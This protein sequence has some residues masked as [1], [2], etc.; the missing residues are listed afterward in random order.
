MR[1]SALIL[2]VSY[3]VGGMGHGPN[4]LQEIPQAS[5]IAL[6][7]KVGPRLPPSLVERWAV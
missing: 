2:S 4:P 6:V 3:P 7:V 5:W 1:G